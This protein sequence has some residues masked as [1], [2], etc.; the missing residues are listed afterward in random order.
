MEEVNFDGIAL[1]GE[2]EYTSRLSTN[3]TGTID[4]EAGTVAVNVT[5]TNIYEIPP[6]NLRKMEV[7]I[8]RRQRQQ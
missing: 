7:S 3:A 2:E 8:Q 1:T 4:K 6:L 5:V